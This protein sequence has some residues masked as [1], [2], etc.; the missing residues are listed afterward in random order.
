MADAPIKINQDQGI[1]GLVSS[2]FKNDFG[3]PFILTP[4]QVDIFEA[5][6]TKGK[7][8]GKKRLHIMTFTQFGKSDVVSMATLLRVS[9]Y[10]EKWCLVAPSQSKA[11]IIIGYLIRHIFDNEY[12]ISRFKVKSGENI[13][14]IRRERSKNRI[15]FDVGNNALGEVF[16]LSAESKIK[17]EDVGNAMMGFG[18]PNVI[19]DEAALI[20]DEA[21]A[22]AMRMVGGFS[23][24][25]DDFVVKIGNPFKRSHFLKAQRDS[26]YYKINIDCYKGIEEKRINAKFVEEMSEKPFF[27]VLYQNKFPRADDIDAKGWSQILTEED[28]KRA[29]LKE[30]DEVKHVG[31]LRIGNDVA[32]GGANKTVWTMR[33]MNFAEIIA[34][35]AQDDLM[36]VGSRGIMIMED[37][38]VKPID[39]FI[40]S[41]GIGAGVVDSIHRER[42]D[43]KGVNVANIALEY[44][45]YT[46]I[47]AEAYWRAREWLLKGGKLNHDDRWYQLCTIKYKPDHK[48]RVRIMSKDDMRSQ[49]IDSPDVADAFMLTFTRKEH[50]DIME[51]QRRRRDKR[52]HTFNRGMKVTMGGY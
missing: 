18:A 13:E 1:K 12:F 2:L 33:S 34:T 43:V 48:Q 19:M 8:V 11:R 14:S 49:G 15:T 10:A 37:K 24:S 7:S 42:K 47:R 20:S 22:K 4:T 28:V 38:K 16:I 5:I 50:G 31:E 23:H 45:K 26:S 39:F 6:F 25:D 52:K 30:G 36:D 41:V 51:H 44:L 29:M 17:S 21:D 9:T 35:S 40:D 46:N 27:G 32:H 3:D